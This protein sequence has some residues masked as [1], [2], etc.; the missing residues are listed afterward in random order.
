MSRI[1]SIHPGFFKDERLVACSAFAR[2]LFVGIGVEADDKGVFEWK[3][4]TL[5]M[6]VFPADNVDVAELLAELEAADAVRRYEMNGRQYGAI[7]NFRRFQKPKTPNDIY[8]APIDI[9]NYVGLSGDASETEVD[10]VPSF[11]PKGEKGAQMEDGGG[12]EEEEKNIS[13]DAER[14]FEDWYG[15]YPR[16]VGKG[17]ARKAYRTA[18][19]KASAAELLAGAARAREQYRGKEEQYIPH[20]SSWLNAERWL[21]QPPP[22][23]DWRDDPDMRGVL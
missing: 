17:A 19:K 2:L 13:L 9:R 4:L 6:T 15:S 16:H 20:P 14:E 1:R 21:D 23:R 8:P 12:K 22:K 10:E 5:K 7:R 18:R 3:P 11:P